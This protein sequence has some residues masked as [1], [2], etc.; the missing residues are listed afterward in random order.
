MQQGSPSWLRSSVCC[1]SGLHPLLLMTFHHPGGPTIFW[2]SNLSLPPPLAACRQHLSTLKSLPT[3]L[4]L[5]PRPNLRACGAG[6]YSLPQP[7]FLTKRV[8]LTVPAHFLTNSFLHTMHSGF[9]PV[10]INFSGQSYN[11]FLWTC[12]KDTFLSSSCLSSLHLKMSSFLDSASPHTPSWLLS[13]FM[14][15]RILCPTSISDGPP[16]ICPSPF[17]ILTLAFFSARIWKITWVISLILTVLGTFC[18]Y[19]LIT[20]KSL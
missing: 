2:N 17:R 1:Y 13:L 19:M 9:P 6:I 10:S 8:K 20:F 15:Q 11:D 7:H 4:S 18:T 14:L 5:L 3:I 12:P 16:S